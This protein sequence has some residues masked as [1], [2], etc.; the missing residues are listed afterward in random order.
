MKLF[1]ADLFHT[2]VCYNYML[3][4]IKCK[5]GNNFDI[6]W[7]FMI[8]LKTSAPIVCA[9][10]IALDLSVLL[11]ETFILIYYLYLILQ[12]LYFY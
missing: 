8:Y 12:S 5:L 6:F 4:V 11:K 9:L 10:L 7:L 2:S 3:D 1:L